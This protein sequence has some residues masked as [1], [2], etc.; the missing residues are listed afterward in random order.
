M[1]GPLYNLEIYWAEAAVGLVAWYNK[2]R[3]SS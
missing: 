1:R 3:A 2:S